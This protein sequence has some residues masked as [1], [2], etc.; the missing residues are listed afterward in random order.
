MNKLLPIILFASLSACSPAPESQLSSE[1]SNLVEPQ[2]STVS[3]EELIRWQ[4][5]AADVTISRDKWGIA[6][7]HGKTD[8]ETVCGTL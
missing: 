6:H 5:Q 3:P 2:S 4:Q 1:L 7:I 8:A